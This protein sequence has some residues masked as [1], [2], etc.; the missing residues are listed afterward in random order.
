[1]VF[2]VQF[3]WSSTG[4]RLWVGFA[5]VLVLVNECVLN[6]SGSTVLVIVSV[7]EESFLS[8]SSELSN[9]EEESEPE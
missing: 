1:M 6:E 4:L 5:V 2:G 8:L 9:S 7:V 3:E